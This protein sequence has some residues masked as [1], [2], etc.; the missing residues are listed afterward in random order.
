MRQRDMNKQELALSVV[1]LA[2]LAAILAIAFQAWL[3]PN[4]LISF[5]N[6]VLCI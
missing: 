1:G 5:A 2:V 3:S 4:M 6:F